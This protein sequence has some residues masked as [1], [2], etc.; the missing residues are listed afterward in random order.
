[1]PGGSGQWFGRGIVIQVDLATGAPT[2][3]IVRASLVEENHDIGISVVS[4]EA[5]I[6][7]V[8]VRKTS[9]QQGDGLFGDGVVSTALGAAAGDR[10]KA[11][12]VSPCGLL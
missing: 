9:P 11:K 10:L 2:S 3:A 12:Y 1:M 6:E 5:A 7:D 4:A 8:V